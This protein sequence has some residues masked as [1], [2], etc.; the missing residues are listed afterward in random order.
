MNLNKGGILTYEMVR[1]CIMGED[2]VLSDK[3]TTK[4]VS[5]THLQRIFFTE[6]ISYIIPK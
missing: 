3:D 2:V 5:Y 4:S 1:Q 6:K